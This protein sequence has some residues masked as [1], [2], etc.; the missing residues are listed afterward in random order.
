MKPNM[1]KQRMLEIKRAIVKL[2]NPYPNDDLILSYADYLKVRDFLRF[3]QFNPTVF[4]NLLIIAH[5]VWNSE[6]RVDKLLLF[7]KISQYY[8]RSQTAKF[9]YYQIKGASNHSELSIETRKLLFELFIKS[10]EET[11]FIKSNQLDEIR[12]ICNFITKNSSFTIT[13]EKW[14]CDNYHLNNIILN[15]LLKYCSKS[16][17][18][19]QWA[20]N[21]FEN[22]TLRDKRAE[23]ISWIIDV[24]PSFEVSQKVLIDDFEYLN[25]SDLKAIQNY[26]DEIDAIKIIEQDLSL[27]LTTKFEFNA[28]ED[29]LYVEKVDLSQPEL[30]LSKRPY[31]TIKDKSKAYPISIP[32]FELLK[33]EFYA[34]IATHQKIT[35][36]W[37]IAFSRLDNDTKVLL[38]QK[39]YNQETHHSVLKVCERLENIKLL[40]L[41]LKVEDK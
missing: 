4:Q 40:K 1:N 27:Y 21:N 17:T 36:I 41:I 11:Q 15:Q 31:M 16:K 19:S 20:K 9:N 29:D 28:F 23:L 3:Y 13:E 37:A 39:Y 34:R 14:L 18:I 38:I 32:D 25:E 26:D 6:K 33:K 10:F 30:K 35:M 12:S 8:Q 2:E 5:D 7:Q 24:N 22:N